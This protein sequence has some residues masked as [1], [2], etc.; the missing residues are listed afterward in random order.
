MSS[1]KFIFFIIFISISIIT[2]INLRIRTRFTNNFSISLKK[3]EI[4]SNIDAFIENTNGVDSNNTTSIVSLPMTNYKNSRFVGNIYLGN[5]EQATEVIF[6]TG[7]G[8]IWITSDKCT[9]GCCSKMKDCFILNTSETIIRQALSCH[10]Q[11]GRGVV[12]GESY[13]ETVRLGSLIVKNASIFLI[14]KEEGDVFC[15]VHGIFGLGLPDLSFKGTTPINDL[16]SSLFEEEYKISFYLKQNSRISFGSVDHSLYKGKLNYFKVEGNSFWSI[17]IKDIYYNN[18]SLNLCE[19]VKCLAAIDSGT[20]F[21]TGPSKGVKTLLETINI[22][23]SCL[24]YNDIGV[25]SFLFDDDEGNTVKYDLLKESFIRKT[26]G[27][28]KGCCKSLIMELDISNEI[29]YWVLGDS[30]MME[31]LSVFDYKNRKVGFGLA[32]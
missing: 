26:E 6:D 5:P 31:L 8:N 7:S 17:R 22:N 27:E 30:F 23:D 13:K 32:V 16:I 9:V 21:I 2:S 15:D 29:D 24:N 14:E 12:S 10:V 4:T 25:I 28:V 3:R 19:N 18:Q 1:K 20:T 11:F